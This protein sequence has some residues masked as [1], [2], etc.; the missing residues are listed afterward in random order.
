MT[1]APPA[2]RDARLKES[3]AFTYLLLEKADM[4]VV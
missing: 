4:R 2:L 1:A 3:H